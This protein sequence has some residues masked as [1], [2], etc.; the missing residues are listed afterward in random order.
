LND[1]RNDSSDDMQYLNIK[2]GYKKSYKDNEKQ[3]S[4][5]TL[6]MKIFLETSL[7]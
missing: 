2:N 7:F 6:M 1:G 3:T 4:I 5:Q